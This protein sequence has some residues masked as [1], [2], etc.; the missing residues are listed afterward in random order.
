MIF[1]GAMV[2]VVGEED[3]RAGDPTMDQKIPKLSE[4]LG[5]LKFR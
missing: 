5:I 4:E 3:V 1:D 2:W